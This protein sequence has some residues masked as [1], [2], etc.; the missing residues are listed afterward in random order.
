MIKRNHSGDIIEL[1]ETPKALH[2]KRSLKD[3]CG[4]I[5]ER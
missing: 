4:S 3:K 5:Q 2:T 1:L